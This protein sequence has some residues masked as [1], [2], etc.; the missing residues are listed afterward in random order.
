VA[1]VTPTQG[2]RFLLVACGSAI[3][4][5]GVVVYAALRGR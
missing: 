5:I 4:L 3:L 2:Y 1:F